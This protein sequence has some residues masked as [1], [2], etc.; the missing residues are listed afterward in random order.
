MSNPNKQGAYTGAIP[1]HASSNLINNTNSN[2]TAAIVKSNS[3][4]SL[5]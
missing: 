1:S 4:I 5:A 3:Q 2:N